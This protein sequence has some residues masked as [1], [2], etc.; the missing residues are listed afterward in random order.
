M[1]SMKFITPVLLAG[2]MSVTMFSCS[3]SDN[4][5]AP[6]VADTTAFKINIQATQFAPNPLTMYLGPKLT[7]TNNDTDA[8]SIVSDDATSF[9]SGNI[10]AGGSFS[11]TPAATG[12]Y[13]YHCG[14][15]PTVKGI[16]YVVTR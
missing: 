4:Y 5:V 10:I 7:W 11:F 14:I 16:L 9:S 15:H 13:E 6:V 12:T 1:K 3:K 8:H 2:F